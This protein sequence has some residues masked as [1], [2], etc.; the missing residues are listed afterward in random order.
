MDL[1]SEYCPQ[2]KHLEE[3]SWKLISTLSTLTDRLVML[4]GK[5][6]TEFMATKVRCVDVKLE[7]LHSRCQLLAHRF[8]H[9]C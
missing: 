1:T 2:R 3:C 5:D 4:V 6:H 9:G 8:A 7:I